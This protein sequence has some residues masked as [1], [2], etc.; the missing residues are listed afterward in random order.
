LFELQCTPE[1]CHFAVSGGKLLGEVVNLVLGGEELI[2]HECRRF[3]KIVVGEG[4]VDHE[5]PLADG[6]SGYA[7]RKLIERSLALRDGY[8]RFGFSLHV[9]SR[10]IHGLAAG[11]GPSCFRRLV[12]CLAY[13]ASPGCGC[14][15]AAGAP[16]GS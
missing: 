10:A 11:R 15:R 6:P 16:Y 13:G 12:G 7:T 4:S 1:G 14:T 9:L 3:G 5:S 2:R 8:Y